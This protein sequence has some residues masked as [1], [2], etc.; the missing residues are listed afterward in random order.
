[1]AEAGIVVDCYGTPVQGVGISLSEYPEIS[2]F[3]DEAGIFYLPCALADSSTLDI[4]ATTL[5]LHLTPPWWQALP[6]YQVTGDEHVFTCGSPS[7]IVLGHDLPTH[8]VATWSS[9]EPVSNATLSIRARFAEGGAVGGPNYVVATEADG[10]FVVAGLTPGAY[11]ARLFS[12]H[13][14]KSTRPDPIATHIG[15][16]EIAGGLN[17]VFDVPDGRKLTVR[18]VDCNESPVAGVHWG[19]WRKADL[20]RD[21]GAA[22]AI[23]SGETDHDGSLELHGLAPGVYVVKRTKSRAPSEELLYMDVSAEQLIVVEESDEFVEIPVYSA[24]PAHLEVSIQADP[25]MPERSSEAI[26]AWLTIECGTERFRQELPLVAL[27]FSGRVPS[28]SGAVEV[29]GAGGHVMA[30]RPVVLMPDDSES[31]RVTIPD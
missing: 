28:G 27:R 11:D 14:Y 19:V 25:A 31:L 26:E 13:S 9:G 22:Y 24:A 18:A 12:T 20:D 29:Q 7:K 30:R 1:M 16:E 3:T 6:D 4:D 21:R 15:C 23:G 17:F 5:P 2:T 10:S 8:G